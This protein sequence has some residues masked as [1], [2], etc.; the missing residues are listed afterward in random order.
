VPLLPWLAA[1]WWGMAAGQWALR[2]RPQWL[3]WRLGCRL[4]QGLA[5]MGRWSLS[6]YLLHQP[7]LMGLLAGVGWLLA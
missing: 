1:V 6:Y 5:L 4:G 2:H 7:V 3:E